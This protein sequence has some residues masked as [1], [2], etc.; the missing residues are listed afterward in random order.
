MNLFYSP[1]PSVELQ[2]TLKNANERIYVTKDKNEIVKFP[3]Y[4]HDECLSGS[5][6]VKVNGKTQFEH[7]GLT[8]HF[9]GHMNVRN[10]RSGSSEFLHSILT[11]DTSGNVIKNERMFSFEF[12]NIEKQYETYHGKYFDV[13]YI[14]RVNLSRGKYLSAIISEQ[15]IYIQHLKSPSLSL[16]DH[17]RMEVGIQDCLHLE[18]T[19]N[20]STYHLTD[21]IIGK[22]LFVLIRISIKSME[23]TLLR[24]ESVG[25]GSHRHIESEIMTKYE[26]LDGAPKKGDSIPVRL[27]LAPYNLTPTYRH[28][29]LQCS[30]RYYLN[31]VL[32]DIEDRRYFKQQEL[33][34][35]R[36][37]VE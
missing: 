15:E 9:I 7:C 37:S 13:R 34:L 24:R 10:D 16:L 1:K 18:F 6:N 27:Y 32:V 12:P 35:W 29:E 28:I 2:V 8:L 26:I 36:Q 11:L 5:L 23:L 4:Y 31:L 22:I 19:S 25:H 20:Q 33:V 17:M 3:L 21:V 30:V 14:L